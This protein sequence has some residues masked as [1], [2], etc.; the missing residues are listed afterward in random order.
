MCCS[1][2]SSCFPP[3]C[4]GTGMACA[5]CWILK[6]CLWGGGGREGCSAFPPF[7][8]GLCLLCPSLLATPATQHSKKCWEQ[9]SNPPSSALHSVPTL[10]ICVFLSLSLLRN[11]CLHTAT[12]IAFPCYSASGDASFMA[13][14]CK[15]ASLAGSTSSLWC[16]CLDHSRDLT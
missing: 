12:F 16:A 15:A 14:G 9:F 4:C 3:P 5:L 11:L 10:L 2:A 7:M 13:I 6:L 8:S 1:P